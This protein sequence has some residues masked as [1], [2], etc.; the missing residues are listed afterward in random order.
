MDDNVLKRYTT[1]ATRASEY[2]QYDQGWHVYA[3]KHTHTHI[4]THA[5]SLTTFD[6]TFFDISLF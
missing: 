3:H 2:V 4:R 5:H 1:T 6:L